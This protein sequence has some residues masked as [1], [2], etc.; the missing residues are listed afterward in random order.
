[1]S[2]LNLVRS[3]SVVSALTFACGNAFAV[4]HE[5]AS[6]VNCHL[7]TFPQG[8]LKGSDKDKGIS[9]SFTGLNANAIESNSGDIYSYMVSIDKRNQGIVI[10]LFLE[11]QSRF[12]DGYRSRSILRLNSLNAG[13]EIL[14]QGGYYE[15]ELI[16]RFE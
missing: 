1:M 7:K 15:I 11:R 8:T 12:D 5:E 3:I 10:E 2:V 14:I 13:Q 6:K 16:C 9:D 4:V